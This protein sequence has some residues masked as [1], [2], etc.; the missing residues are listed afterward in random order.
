MVRNPKKELKPV[1]NFKRKLRNLRIW[2]LVIGCAALVIY[3]SFI[4]KT[5]DGTY[6]LSEQ[7]KAKLE[8]ELEELENAEQYVL[9]ASQNGYYPCFSCVE[10]NTIFL[11]IGQ[12]WRYGVT[13][14]GERGRY[15]S[16]LLEQRL[17]YVPQYQ[18]LLQECLREE[19]IKIYNYAL[20]PENLSRQLPLIRPPGNKQDN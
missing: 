18:G 6:E 20:L 15:G 12:V 17:L 3:F 5:L 16:S 9:L 7:R 2:M 1:P 13:Q 14:K 10:K 11:N 8:K 19:K 4:Q